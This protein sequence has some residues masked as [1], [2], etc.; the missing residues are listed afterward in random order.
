MRFKKKILAAVAALPFLALAAPLASAATPEEIVQAAP[1]NAWR[2]VDP[3]DLLFMD[4]PSG[5]II[6]E[7]REDFAPLHVER[8]KTLTRQGFY[9][10][11]LFHRVIEGFMAQ[12]GDPTG[13]GTGSSDLPNLQAEFM[14]DA[15][16]AAATGFSAIGRDARSPRLGFIGPIP[17]AAQPETMKDFLVEDNIALWGMHCRGVMSMARAGD[18]NSANSQFFLMF[19]DS[20]GS[21]D[22]KYTVWGRIVDGFENARRINRGEPPE[23]PTPIVRMRL[24]SDVPVEDRDYVEVLRTD[25]QE[26][27]NYLSAGAEITQDGYVKDVCNI[28]IPTKINGE[29]EL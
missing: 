29:I 11:L 15:T 13:T 5:R 6:I 20:R 27:R 18:P 8:I 7:L 19:G 2:Y 1:E 21:L 16:E 24:G 9:D 23:R 10:G 3:D 28:R 26:F 25:G 4:L 22:Q 14:R 12:G 17:V